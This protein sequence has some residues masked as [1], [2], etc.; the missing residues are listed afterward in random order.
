M[1]ASTVDVLK[2]MRQECAIRF[3]G[4]FRELGYNVRYAQILAQCITFEAEEATRRF[5]GLP[6]ALKS[7]RQNNEKRNA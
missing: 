7:R 6:S 2:H 3:E 1:N 4:E 5:F